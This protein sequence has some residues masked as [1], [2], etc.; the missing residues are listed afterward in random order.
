MAEWKD[1]VWWSN[2]G[3]R[4]HFRDYAGP[5]DKPPILCIPGLTRN[6]RDYTH[7]AERL[8]GKWRI[9]VAELR[10]RGE[11]AYAKDAMT[12]TPLTYLQDIEALMVSQGL[13]RAVFFGTSLGGIVTMLLA[14]TKPEQI[15]GALLNDIGPAIE[16]EGVAH[17]R[18]YVGRPQSHPSWLHAAR[19]LALSQGANYP[20]FGLEDWLAL[21]KRI[22]KL[23][24]AGR[25][26]LDYDMRI[27]EPFKM[28]GGEAGV[29]L[30]PALAGLSGKPV[31]LVRGEH[32]LI[33]SAATAAEMA[34]RI[35]GLAIVTVRDV[36]HAPIL[37]EAES[38]AAIDELLGRVEEQERRRGA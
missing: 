33:L 17:I 4:L 20:R 26:V 1:G 12:Y 9:L 21:A 13:A 8:A 28:P 38:T 30:W 25:V 14:A 23:S 10:G 31:S 6:A 37:D 3:L 2:D 11:S 27:A 18:S 32:S 15:A 19:A 35:D 7:V 36:G 34:R 24:P 22:F 16:E 5:A 29:D